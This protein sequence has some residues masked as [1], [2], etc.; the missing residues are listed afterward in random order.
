MGSRDELAPKRGRYSVADK[1]SYCVQEPKTH[2]ATGT[3]ADTLEQPLCDVVHPKLSLSQSYIL[4]A[5]PCEH[6]RAGTTEV[7]DSVNEEK[8]TSQEKLNSCD[9]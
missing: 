3:G 2:S 8:E 4:G 5:A 9:F 1:S 6:F 7:T